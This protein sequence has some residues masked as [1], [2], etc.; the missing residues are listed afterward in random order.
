MQDR[1]PLAQRFLREPIEAGRVAARPGEACHKAELDRVLT[2][3]E[4][5]RDSWCCCSCRDRGRIALRG[6]HGYA[7]AD[8]F[9][10]HRRQAVELAVQDMILDCHRC[11]PLPLSLGGTR[12][13]A[14]GRISDADIADHRQRS[15]LGVGRKRPQRRRTAESSDEFAPS[16]ANAHLPLPVRGNLSRQHSTARACGGGAR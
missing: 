10:H 15:L 7:P 1:E 12:A 9:G 3:D 2:N 8:Q 14:P 6:D 11:S 4:D 16:K 13:H 5:N